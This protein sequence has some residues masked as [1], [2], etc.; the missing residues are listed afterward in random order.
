[1]LVACAFLFLPEG[2]NKLFG[3]FC[4]RPPAILTVRHGR[5]LIARFLS[6]VDLEEPAPFLIS[7]FMEASFIEPV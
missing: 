4:S 3:V 1:I 6:T 2:E 5:T 7:L